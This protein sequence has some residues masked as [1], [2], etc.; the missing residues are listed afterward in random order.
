MQGSKQPQVNTNKAVA[1]S[2]RAAERLHLDEGS[3]HGVVDLC[4]KRPIA[5]NTLLDCR[6]DIET[7]SADVREEKIDI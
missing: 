2:E 5:I 7:L 1:W 3:E 6:R 4:S